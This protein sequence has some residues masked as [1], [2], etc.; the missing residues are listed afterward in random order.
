MA[1][2]VMAAGAAIALAL[3]QPSQPLPAADALVVAVRWLLAPG[4]CLLAG[5]CSAAGR[6]FFVAW[7]IDGAPPA[8]GSALDITLRY[9]LNTIEQTVLAAI[10]WCG[11]AVAAP[12]RAAGMIPILAGLFVAGRAAFW[13]GYLRAPWARAFG[14][15]LT[16]Y[17]TVGVLAWLA[18][19]HLRGALHG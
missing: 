10:A 17:P 6:R 8:A 2:S 19:H 13:A 7:S 12:E 3:V 16:F 14:F 1:A 15:G 5:I 9:N 4:L 11:L 18:I